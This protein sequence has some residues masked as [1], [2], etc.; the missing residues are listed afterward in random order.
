VEFVYKEDKPEGKGPKAESCSK[1]RQEAI[2]SLPAALHMDFYKAVESV[3]FDKAMTIVER[4]RERDQ[5]LATDLAELL[6]SYR[7]DTLQKL[8]KE[9]K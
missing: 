6:N 5:E 7:F 3:D 8:F 2:A 1:P 9:N 4:I